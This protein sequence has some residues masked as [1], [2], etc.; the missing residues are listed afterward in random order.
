MLSL[1]KMHPTKATINISEICTICNLSSFIPSFL[2]SFLHTC[3]HTSCDS[4]WPII[5]SRSVKMTSVICSHITSM[6]HGRNKPINMSDMTQNIQLCSARSQVYSSNELY[7]P[8][9]IVADHGHTITAVRCCDIGSAE[10]K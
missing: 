3:L 4:E 8:A 9:S 2:L 7:E 1:L 6:G 5:I 10:D